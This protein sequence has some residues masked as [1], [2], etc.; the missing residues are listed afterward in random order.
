MILILASPGLTLAQEPDSE[1]PSREQVLAPEEAAD[2]PDNAVHM[3]TEPV[4]A[5]PWNLALPALHL[6]W[7]GLAAFI[8]VRRFRHRPP[9]PM[10]LSE[11][12]WLGWILLLAALLAWIAQSLGA[13]SAAVLMGV[14]E[15]DA[16]TLRASALLTIGAH[17][18]T[19]AAFG[20][21]L[22]IASMRGPG[23]SSW[24]LVRALGARP[25]ILDVPRIVGA[26]LLAHPFI[27]LVGL[28]GTLVAQ[29]ARGG[30]PID[31]LA[32]DTLRAMTGEGV[33]VWWI[34]SVV[35]AVVVA[36]V[37]EELVYRG[38]LQNA[39]TRLGGQAWVAIGVTSLVFTLMHTGAV[40]THALPTIFVLSVAFGVIYR[41]TGS[42]TVCI[43]VHG[44][45]NTINLLI[46]VA[47]GSG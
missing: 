14:S 39:I 11:A 7:G 34:A 33:G 10:P 24:H 8:L 35:I 27:W 41:R 38:L 32:H 1:A 30:E 47:L 44:L 20:Y 42:L 19:L 15:I 31:P 17:V 28:A 37:A 16:G 29:L 40:A 26:Y 4:E 25:S 21:C 46:A 5:G 43:G 9:A 6:V 18:G 45:F 2:E 3:P 22:V 36:P 13:A 12:S 23:A